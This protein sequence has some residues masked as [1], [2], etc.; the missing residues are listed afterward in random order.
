MLLDQDRHLMVVLAAL[1]LED[2]AVH[3]RINLLLHRMTLDLVIQGNREVMR[4]VLALPQVDQQV[5][6]LGDQNESEKSQRQNQ[7]SLPCEADC[8]RSTVQ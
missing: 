8:K 7:W 2:Q 3:R 4:P 1:L 6:D 5:S